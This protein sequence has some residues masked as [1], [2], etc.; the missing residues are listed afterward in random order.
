MLILSSSNQSVTIFNCFCTA[1]SV[2]GKLSHYLLYHF[3]SSRFLC[4]WKIS[5]GTVEIFCFSSFFARLCSICIC[6]LLLRYLTT[7]ILNIRYSDSQVCFDYE[8]CCNSIIWSTSCE[9]CSHSIND[10]V[11]LFHGQRSCSFVC[12]TITPLSLMLQ[13]N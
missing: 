3:P 6:C 12:H 7:S 2:I 9:P 8:S 1:L 10:L 5:N 11:V 4:N 13:L